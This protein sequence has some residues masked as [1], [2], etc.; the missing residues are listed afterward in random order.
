MEP[1]NF[2]WVVTGVLAGMARPTQPQ[3]YEYLVSHGITELVSLTE[4]LPPNVPPSIRSLHLPIPDFCPPTVEQAT[5]FVR[6]VDRARAEGKAV[7]VHCAAGIGRTGTMLACYVAHAQR[8]AAG[9]AV[10][11]VRG[12]RP[13][14]VETAEQEDLV[15]AFVLSDSSN[16]PASSP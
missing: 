2:S 16:A 8:L 5:S 6:F 7:G 1:K 9:E 11:R 14:S 15:A 10:R 4:S 13:G 12:L 3:H